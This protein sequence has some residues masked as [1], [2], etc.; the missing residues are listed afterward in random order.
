MF[1]N[2]TYGSNPFLTP[3]NGVVETGSFN[4]RQLILRALK[5]N[6]E[7]ITIENGFSVD[8]KRVIFGN[9]VSELQNG[10]ILIYSIRDLA[11]LKNQI[12]ELPPHACLPGPFFSVRNVYVKLRLK[13]KGGLCSEITDSMVDLRENYP[14]ALIKALKGRYPAARQ[15]YTMLLDGIS[16]GSGL[17]AFDI[18]Q[19]KEY[20]F[21]GDLDLETE[22][23][24]QYKEIFN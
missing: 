16:N 24:L 19:F 8:I 7:A 15:L 2:F 12:P 22:I 17:S 6:L 5:Q 9:T 13:V 14:D 21:S 11:V 23:M 3:L 10:D 20:T 4:C 18:S 1:A